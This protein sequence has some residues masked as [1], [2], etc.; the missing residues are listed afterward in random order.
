MNKE[1]NKQATCNE[2]RMREIPAR[3]YKAADVLID[4]NVVGKIVDSPGERMYCLVYDY[5]DIRGMR[6][7]ETVRG[8]L[9]EAQRMY[10]RS[11]R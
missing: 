3:H 9:D 10:E 2:F 8:C 7:R 6:A 4:G 11:G 1:E 5:G